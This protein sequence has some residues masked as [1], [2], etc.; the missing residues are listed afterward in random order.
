M[1]Q[2]NHL[3]T[4][5]SLKRSCTGNLVT[6]ADIKI[7]VGEMAAWSSSIEGVK[8]LRL[9]FPIQLKVGLLEQKQIL[10][11]LC[12]QPSF[13]MNGEVQPHPFNSSY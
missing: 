4:L 3:V 11:F 6:L 13:M 1:W 9:S 5:N 12:K 2:Q 10:V 7:V 8:R